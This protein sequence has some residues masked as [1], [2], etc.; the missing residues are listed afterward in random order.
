MTN[1]NRTIYQNQL[2]NIK[3][4]EDRL[5]YALAYIES[6]EEDNRILSHETDLQRNQIIS[7]EQDAAYL[8]VL[9]AKISDICT[10]KL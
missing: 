10:V 1:I 4:T 9:L 6:L 7:L 8:R 3:S 5:A 2:Y